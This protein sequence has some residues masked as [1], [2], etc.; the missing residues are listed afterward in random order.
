MDAWAPNVAMLDPGLSAGALRTLQRRLRAALRPVWRERWAA[1]VEA[2]EQPLLELGLPESLFEADD[3]LSGAFVVEMLAGLVP[4]LS[5]LIGGDGP[6][7]AG[8]LYEALSPRCLIVRRASSPELRRPAPETLAL[9]DALARLDAPDTS[10]RALRATPSARM[11]AL[12]AI[13][14]RSRVSSTPA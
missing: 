10:R 3:L 2:L 12:P 13:A 9:A 14:H 8:R 6:L 11:P 4:E 7:A 1:R 5:P